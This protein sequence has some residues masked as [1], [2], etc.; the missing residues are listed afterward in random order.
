[1]QTVFAPLNRLLKTIVAVLCGLI[2]CGCVTQPSRIAETASGKPE[3]VIKG[4]TPQAANERMTAHFLSKGF[5]LVNET[6]SQVTFSKRVTEFAAAME[7]RT[8]LGSNADSVGMQLTFTSVNVQGGVK[9]FC[10]ASSW[11]ELPNGKTNRMAVRDND[12]FNAY[13]AF[14]YKLR[15]SF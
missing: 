3:V 15:D 12:I 4:V 5:D 14:L 10:D 8:A 6:P 1:M 11:A 9:V 2:L 13:Q 7:L